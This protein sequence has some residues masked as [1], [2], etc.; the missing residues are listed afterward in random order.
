MSIRPWTEGLE[1][2]LSEMRSRPGTYDQMALA[3]CVSRS[4]VCE[5]IEDDLHAHPE[6]KIPLPPRG[7]TP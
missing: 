4:V 2:R 7:W 3:L 1:Q 6:I 5:H